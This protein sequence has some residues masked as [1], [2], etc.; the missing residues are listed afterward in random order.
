MRPSAGV[1]PW[2]CPHPEVF[3]SVHQDALEKCPTTARRPNMAD[4]A[5]LTRLEPGSGP[6]VMEKGSQ[7]LE[8][9]LA[10]ERKKVHPT[11]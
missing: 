5:T 2:I 8:E 11:G 9:S 7:D 4:R 1:V 3:A 10:V 6:S